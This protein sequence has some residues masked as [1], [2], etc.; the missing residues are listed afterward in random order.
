M[1]KLHMVRIDGDLTVTGNTSGPEVTDILYVTQDGNDLNDGKSMGPD[2]AKATIKAAV[3]AAQPGA[4]Y[5][6]STNKPWTNPGPFS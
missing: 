6:T 5:R 2:G 1:V 3:E 4:H